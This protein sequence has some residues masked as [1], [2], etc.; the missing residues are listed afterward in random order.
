MSSSAIPAAPRRALR[1]QLIE[2][3]PTLVAIVTERV[4]KSIVEGEFKLGEYI[5]EDR[6]ATSLGV[7]RTPVREAMTGL[8]LQGLVNIQPQRGTF[9]FL[10]TADEAAAM[11]EFRM[12]VECRAM[13]LSL[14]RDK[15]RALERLRACNQDMADAL[16]RGDGVA[17]AHADSAFHNVLFAYCGNKYLAAAYALLSPQIDAL[18]NHLSRTV[19]RNR[20]TAF[21]EHQEIIDA[22]GASDLSRAESLLSMHIFKMRGH[23][24]EALETKVLP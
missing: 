15:E 1:K 8:Q 23:Y 9:V 10:P 7:S 12:I 19:A 20:P 24:A 22:F 18:R 13:A 5:S 17:S 14:A 11:C 21:G 2:R 4:R 6:V 16:E 3:P